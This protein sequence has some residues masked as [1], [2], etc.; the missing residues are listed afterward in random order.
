MQVEELGILVDRDDQ[1]CPSFQPCDLPHSG[2][3]S[4][5]DITIQVVKWLEQETFGP[6]QWN[7][8]VFLY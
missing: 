5:I 3:Q 6:A 1:V 8:D 4:A 7:Q 2:S